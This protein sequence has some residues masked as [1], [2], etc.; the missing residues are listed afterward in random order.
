MQ[1]CTTTKHTAR[2]QKHRFDLG[3]SKT[4]PA[5]A[6]CSL[7]SCPVAFSPLQLPIPWR[8]LSPLQS[9]F[10]FPSRLRLFLLFVHIKF[11][12][13][14]QP[15]GLKFE[16]TPPQIPVPLSPNAPR[17]VCALCKLNTT[18]GFLRRPLPL[19]AFAPWG[20]SCSKGVSSRSRGSCRSGGFGEFCLSI[21]HFWVSVISLARFPVLIRVCSWN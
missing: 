8:P 15:A 2:T 10:P 6:L 5:S 20:D 18:K 1:P 11:R 3:L 17:S 19:L 9:T 12:A 21:C 7:P 14:E 16:L 4:P 13:S